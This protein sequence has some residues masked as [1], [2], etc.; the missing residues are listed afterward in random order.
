MHLYYQAKSPFEEYPNKI[1]RHKALQ[2]THPEKALIQH[3]NKGIKLGKNEIYF[4]ILKL[5]GIFNW[6]Q[7]S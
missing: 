3:I 7:I 4:G 2:Q 5:S 1:S 6:S